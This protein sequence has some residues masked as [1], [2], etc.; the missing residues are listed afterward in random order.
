MADWLSTIAGAAYA[1]VESSSHFQPDPQP[2]PQPQPQP[3]TEPQPQPQPQT[4]TPI[5]VPRLAPPGI[6]VRRPSHPRQCH[7]N[8]LHY[9]R[10]AVLPNMLIGRAAPP[11]PPPNNK[12]LKNPVF[13]QHELY[14]HLDIM[15][16]INDFQDLAKACKFSSCILP[17]ALSYSLP[18]VPH[19]PVTDT[20]IP[21]TTVGDSDVDAPRNARF[22]IPARG[23][24]IHQTLTGEVT[25]LP[26][27]VYKND[28]DFSLLNA[29]L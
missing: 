11:L 21:S 19:P 7:H 24:P 2:Q 12:S 13:E 20:N 15:D 22:S 9:A 28:L 3:V 1:F 27:Y 25:T 8:L 6:P 26:E 5:R 18:A 23:Y 17:Q 4:R 10:A 29:L 16:P 14:R